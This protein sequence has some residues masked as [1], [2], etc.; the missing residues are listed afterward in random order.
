MTKHQRSI[1]KEIKNLVPD[2]SNPML[3]DMSDALASLSVNLKVDGVSEK[4]FAHLC[5]NAFRSAKNR[6]G[7]I[8]AWGIK[9]RP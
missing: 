8:K 9:D 1:R 7:N 4:D 6:P 5:I 2:Y 3:D